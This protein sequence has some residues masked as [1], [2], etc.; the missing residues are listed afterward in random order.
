MIYPT[1]DDAINVQVFSDD[2]PVKV[3]SAKGWSLFPAM[4][5]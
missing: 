5:W 2:A 4:Q 1:L 3:E